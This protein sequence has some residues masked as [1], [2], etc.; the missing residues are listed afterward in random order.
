MMQNKTHR[1]TR[2]RQNHV[3]SRAFQQSH[4][5]LDGRFRTD[6][7]EALEPESKRFLK[8]LKLN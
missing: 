7:F 2:T 8:V 5:E 1:K 4:A 6:D 3:Q